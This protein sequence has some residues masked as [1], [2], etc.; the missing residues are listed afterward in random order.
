MRAIVCESFANP[1]SLEIHEILNILRQN[2]AT[3]KEII[4]RA[5]TRIPE[6]RDCGCATALKTAIVTAPELIP[7]AQKQ[8]Y[9]LLIGKYLNQRRY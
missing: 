4:K 2:S 9:D 5:I 1:D 7:S 6:K 3:I 8:K